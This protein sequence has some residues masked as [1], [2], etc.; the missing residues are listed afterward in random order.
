M[1]MNAFI[2]SDRL[3]GWQQGAQSCM[4]GKSP[5][6]SSRQRPALLVHSEHQYRRIERIETIR[7]M[8]QGSYHNFQSHDIENT[9]SPSS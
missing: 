8:K 4:Q 1:R 6:P 7:E 9:I 2:R 5:H 3:P